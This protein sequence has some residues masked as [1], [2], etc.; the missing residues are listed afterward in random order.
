[1]YANVF[2]L[3]SSSGVFGQCLSLAS[4]YGQAQSSFRLVHPIVKEEGHVGLAYQFFEGHVGLP[5]QLLYLLVVDFY[6]SGS[7]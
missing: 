7:H 3:M 4:T 6:V 1:M 2:D 5:Y